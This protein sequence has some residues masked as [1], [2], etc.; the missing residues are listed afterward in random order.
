VIADLLPIEATTEEE[1]TEGEA[2]DAEVLKKDKR[3]SL[4]SI[5]FA[6]LF[7]KGNFLNNSKI[8]YSQKERSTGSSIK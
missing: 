7:E 1:V 5:T 6:P 8:C 3:N 2:T 4:K